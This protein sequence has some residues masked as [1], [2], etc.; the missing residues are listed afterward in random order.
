MQQTSKGHMEEYTAEALK[1]AGWK[2]RAHHYRRFTVKPFLA[3]K[4]EVL[5]GQAFTLGTAAETWVPPSATELAKPDSRFTLL[6]NESVKLSKGRTNKD[7]TK[8]TVRLTV[9][10]FILD[11]RGGRT[12]VE[13]IDPKGKSY[14]GVAHCSD[15]DNYNN[16]TG[17]QV[18]IGHALV[19]P[20]R[21]KK[22]KK[23]VKIV[24]SV[25]QYGKIVAS[26]IR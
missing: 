11:A 10:A 5:T 17:I 1:K 13:L 22:N 19:V 6:S 25:R 18:A 24:G 4:H 26:V 16:S 15:K 23:K 20:V 8:A 3:R 21:Q 9:P 12:D 2:I 14:K 7:G